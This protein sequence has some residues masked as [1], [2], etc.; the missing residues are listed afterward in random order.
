MSTETEAEDVDSP[1]KQGLVLRLLVLHS[2]VIPA[3]CTGISTAA[4]VAFATTYLVRLFAITAGYHRL[5][6]HHAF[7]TSRV[8]AFVLAVVG[9]SSGQR[10]PLWWAGV[11]RRHHRTADTVDDVH[12]PRHKGLLFAHVGWILDKKNLATPLHEVKDW[13]R[14]PELVWLDRFHLLAP[15]SLIV[16]LAAVGALLEHTD[17]ELHTSAAQFVAWGFVLSTIAAIH[18]TSCVNSLTHRYGSR[19]FVT[20]DDSGNIWWL[21][22]PTLGEA[23]HNNH[24]HAPGCVRQGLLWWQVDISYLVLRAL[25]VV[26]VVWNLREPNDK[27]LADAHLAARVAGSR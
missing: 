12:S 17:P 15:T 16:L 24:H 19:P 7:Q 23:W 6:S 22:L 10:G 3:L 2:L 5:F 25:A 21:A 27:V 20:D 26:G 4:V 18:V 9:A 11:H 1:P 8:F 14:F 13:S